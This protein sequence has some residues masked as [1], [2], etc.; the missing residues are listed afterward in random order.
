[1]A[2]VPFFSERAGLEHLFVPRLALQPQTLQLFDFSN[3]YHVIEDGVGGYLLEVAA[4]EWPDEGE[5]KCVATSS[6]GRV[7][8]SSCYVTMDGE[9]NPFHLYAL[10]NTAFKILHQHDILRT[11]LKKVFLERKSKQLL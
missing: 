5:W 3:R 11:K 4:A 7:G 2:E 1:M 6:G 9:K 8:I 10:M